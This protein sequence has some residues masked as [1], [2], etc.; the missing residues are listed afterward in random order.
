[1]TAR[2][3]V[4]ALIEQIIELPDGPRAELID[5]VLQMRAEQLGI[6]GETDPWCSPTDCLRSV[7]M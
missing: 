3:K 7:I 1:M 6:D 5:A 2:Q 4:P